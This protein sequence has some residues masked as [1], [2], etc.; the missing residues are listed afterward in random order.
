[1]TVSGNVLHKKKRYHRNAYEFLFEALRFTQETL[2]RGMVLEGV[3]EDSAHISGKELLDGIRQ[4]AL[5]KYGLLAQSVFRYWGVENT[6]D[7][8]RIVFDLVERGEMRKT[9]RDQLSDF[10][11]LYDF[12]KTFNEDYEIDISE[13]FKVR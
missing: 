2:N 7:F 10:V 1:M 6:E 3:D 4:L 12:H 5:D 11:E 13:A 9:E 8:G